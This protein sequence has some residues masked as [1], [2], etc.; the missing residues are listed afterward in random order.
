MAADDL[1]RTLTAL[2]EQNASAHEETRRHFDQI[3]ERL[4]AENRRHFEITAEEFKHEV[5]LVAEAV[6]QLDQKVGREVG[7]LNEEV[8][9]GFAETQAMLR[10][11]HAELE[12]RVRTLEQ[13]LSELQ[14]RVER[15][16]TT[17]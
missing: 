10:F 15:L 7:R 9:S 3:A 5:R 13:A 16:E 4:A 11:S 6:T 8:G 17:P 2:R 12:L 14:S 1:E